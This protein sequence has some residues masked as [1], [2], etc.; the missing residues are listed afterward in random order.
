M[1]TI[2]V[3]PWRVEVEQQPADL[4]ARSR[5]DRA[6]RLVGEQQRRPV[7][8]RPGDRDA[9]PLAAG[10]PRRVG[11]AAVGDPQRGEQ[12]LRALPGVARP[13]P[14][15]LGGQQHVVDH[16][17]VVEEV[18]ELEDHADLAAAEP[19]RTGLRQHVHPLVADPDRA[20]GR[21]VHPGDEVEQRRLAAARTAP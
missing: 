20:A 9:L 2:S 12:F 21:P 3:W 4:V 13:H 16:R 11:V 6:G 8:E 5:V 18:E 7:D 19:G 17:H 10:Q 15:E 14:G 1:T